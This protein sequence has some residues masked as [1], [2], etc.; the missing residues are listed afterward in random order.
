MIG[1]GLVGSAFAPEPSA[2]ESTWT[3]AGYT[4]REIAEST[5]ELRI[6]LHAVEAKLEVRNAERRAELSAIA[7]K[8]GGEVQALKFQLEKVQE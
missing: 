3:T 4:E 5:A 7:V 8:H 6:K 1:S 2:A